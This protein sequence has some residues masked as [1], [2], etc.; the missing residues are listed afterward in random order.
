MKMV[1]MKEDQVTR[2]FRFR[3]TVKTQMDSDVPFVSRNSMAEV[4]NSKK[5]FSRKISSRLINVLVPKHDRHW[6]ENLVKRKP[7]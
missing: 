3:R 4:K 6:M 7:A 2:L 1:K 5:R